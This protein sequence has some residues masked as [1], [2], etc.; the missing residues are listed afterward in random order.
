MNALNGRLVAV[1]APGAASRPRGRFGGRGGRWMY[2][3]IGL[4]VVHAGSMI[5]MAVIASSDSSFAVEPNYYEQA[6]NWDA[7]AAQKEHNATLGWKAGVT[8]SPL[9]T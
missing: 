9:A 2:I 7:A 8:V 4:L 1:P 6:L 3:F 5:T